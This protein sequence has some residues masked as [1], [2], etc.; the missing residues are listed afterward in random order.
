MDKNF[1]CRFRI[2]RRL[3]GVPISLVREIVRVPEINLRPE[4]RR[5]IIEAVNPSS[6]P[7]IP[8]VDFCAKRFREN[9]GRRPP[10]KNRI[11]D[12]RSGRPG[13][14]VCS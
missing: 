12:S 9:V 8:V 5:K 3:S 14:S 10:K 13:L 7:V 6:R 11:V 1:R 4:Q 2:G